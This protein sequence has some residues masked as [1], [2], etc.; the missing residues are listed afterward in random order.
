MPSTALADERSFRCAPVL[1]SN[2]SLPVLTARTTGVTRHEN[3]LWESEKNSCHAGDCD[4]LGD[5][6]VSSG[7]LGDPPYYRWVL[8]GRDPNGRAGER[9]CSYLESTL[10][11]GV[12]SSEMRIAVRS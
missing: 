9:Y 12:N 8:H 7:D 3:I 10:S 11:S 1:F 4:M 6:A 5:R 2:A